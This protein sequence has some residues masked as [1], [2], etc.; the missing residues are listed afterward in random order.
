MK[1]IFILCIF[2]IPIVLQAQQPT[3]KIS[4]YV[5]GGNKS[6][7]YLKE[8]A[9]KQIVSKTEAK[10]HKCIVFNAGIQFDISEKWRIGASFTYDHFGTKHRSIEYS[11]ISYLLRCDR[12]WK[13]GKN[14]ALYSGLATGFRK[15]REFENEVEIKRKVSLGY[16]IYVAGLNYKLAN[17]FFIDANAGWGVSGILSVGGKYFF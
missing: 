6:S 10:H 1:K 12:V 17:R 9:H 7:S 2:F 4:I 14:Y 15:V 3:K 8:A 5:L 13:N 11:N 16:Q